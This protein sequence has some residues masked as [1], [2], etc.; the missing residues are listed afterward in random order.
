MAPGV[1]TLFGKLAVLGSSVVLIFA[2][3]LLWRRR[4]AAHISAF[5]AQS[6][7]LAATTAVA[8]SF[9]GDWQLYVVA[10]LLLLLK[11]IG[12]PVLLVR[13]DR[14][15]GAER[16]LDPYVN[17]ATSLLVAGILVV[18]AY[19]VT[20]PLVA[21]S[22][23]PT[24]AGMP[25]AMGVIFVS[26]FVIIS[27]K[28]ALTQVIGFLALENGIALLAVLGTYGTPLIVEV[29]VFLDALMGFLVMQI[30]VY[31]IHET[32]ESLDVDR[33]QTLRK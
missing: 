10:G 29:G 23:L 9:T 20:R 4:S 27:R 21:L 16:E 12:I 31:Q 33:L 25:L 8:A 2:L 13:M 15:F 17:T 32:F 26:L 22:Q 28:K 11:G 18:L 30:F 24:R 19:V 7:A 14:R 3:V 6:V 1:A 5:A